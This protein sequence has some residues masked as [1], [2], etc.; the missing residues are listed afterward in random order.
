MKLCV[1]L[2]VNKDVA[3]RGFWLRLVTVCGC[4]QLLLAAELEQQGGDVSKSFDPAV[5]A[6]VGINKLTYCRDFSEAVIAQI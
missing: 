3:M 5:E 4:L 1:P 2:E 6:V